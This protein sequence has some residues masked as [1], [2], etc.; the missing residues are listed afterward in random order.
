VGIADHVDW[1]RKADLL[2]ILA[3]RWH[4]CNIRKKEV[5]NIK[6]VNYAGVYEH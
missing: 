3:F 1:V 2:L 4:S 6:V 5:L